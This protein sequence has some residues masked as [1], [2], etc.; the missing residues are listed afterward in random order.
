MHLMH[1]NAQEFLE[2][3]FNFTEINFNIIIYF[4]TPIILPSSIALIAVT[5]RSY[6][7]NKPFEEIKLDNQLHF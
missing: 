3:D 2:L 7:N 6:T 1:I 4:I 5:M